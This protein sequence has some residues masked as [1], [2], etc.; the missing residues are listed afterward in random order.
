MANSTKPAKSGA[1]NQCMVSNSTTL[2]ETGSQHQTPKSSLAK[3]SVNTSFESSNHKNQNDQLDGPID[4]LKHHQKKTVEDKPLIL[5][6]TPDNTKAMNESHSEAESED[7]EVWYG[8]DRIPEIPQQHFEYS[9]VINDEA[10]KV[11]IFP[12]DLFSISDYA[13]EVNK[14]AEPKFDL[15]KFIIGTKLKISVPQ[16][17]SPYKFWFHIE[18]EISHLDVLMENLG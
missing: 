1:W 9:A 2:T 3:P 12:I 11:D 18:D 4:D 16:T 10:N 7:R 17:F 6:N 8:D 5:F 13:V 14:I 15:F